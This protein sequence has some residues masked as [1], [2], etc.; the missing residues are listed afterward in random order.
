MRLPCD[1][2]NETGVQMPLWIRPALLLAAMS[3]ALLLPALAQPAAAYNK[4]DLGCIVGREP[5]IVGQ[6]P[7][8]LLMKISDGKTYRYDLS[9]FNFK[10]GDS[11]KNDECYRMR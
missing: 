11:L 7:T 10:R 3:T 8:V 1:A 6:Y 2:R 9:R 4:T 5:D